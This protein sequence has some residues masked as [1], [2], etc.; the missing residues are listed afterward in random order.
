MDLSQ[1]STG[2]TYV[3]IMIVPPQD[4]HLYRIDKF[5]NVPTLNPGDRT[6]Y[7]RYTYSSGG[8]AVLEQ[9]LLYGS[10][11]IYTSAPVRTCLHATAPLTVP[12][13]PTL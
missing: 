9:L 1:T 7:P 2:V 5:I 11:S 10:T 6:T 12:T 3:Y 8:D 13:A 4:R